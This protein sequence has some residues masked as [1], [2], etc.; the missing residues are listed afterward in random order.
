MPRFCLLKAYLSSCELSPKV[1]LESR[2]DCVCVCVCVKPLYGYEHMYVGACKNQM[3]L[4]HLILVLGTE[5]WSS[6]Y[7]TSALK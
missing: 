6:A 5:H 3:I 2:R 4:S 1:P 7:I